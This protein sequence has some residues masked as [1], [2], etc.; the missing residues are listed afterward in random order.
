MPVL[1]IQTAAFVDQFFDKL[2]AHG[3]ALTDA[4]ALKA[5]VADL[6][7]AWLGGEEAIPADLGQKLATQIGVQTA[8]T[9]NDFDW[10]NTP[11]NGGPRN[12]GTIDFVLPDGTT[13]PL[14]GRAKLIESMAKGDPGGV[15]FTFST[16][17][18]DADPGPG[19][20]RFNSATLA[21]VTALYFDNTE[22]G[23]ATVTPWLDGF[24]AADGDVKGLLYFQEIETANVAVFKVTASVVDG[25][26]Y[27]KVPVTQAVGAT[28][29]A[30]DA[31]VAVTFT[32]TGPSDYETWKSQPGND[33]GTKADYLDWQ[34]DQVTANAAAVLQ[35]IADD[36]AQSKADAETARNMISGA[37]DASGTL[38]D[39]A[40]LVFVD[41]AQR[42]LGKVNY[43][44]SWDIAF[45][46]L[47]T[48]SGLAVYDY[49]TLDEDAAV[50]VV[51]AAGR[52]L[53]RSDSID[54]ALAEE[55]AAARGNRSALTDRMDV[56][57]TP[58][59]RSRRHVWGEW[60]LRETRARI[61]QIKA[62]V[63]GKQLIIAL[64][65]DSWTARSQ[66]YAAKLTDRLVALL[67]DAGGGWCGFGL[68]SGT[69]PNGNARS[70]LFTTVKTGSGWTTS[71]A[72]S[73]C[74]DI[75]HATSSTPGDQITVAG[76]ALPV[77]SAVRLFWVGTADGVI[78]YRW[79]GGSYTSLNV[80]GSGLQA[81]LL[82]GLP[83]SGSYS[84]DLEVVSGTC[85]LGG[86]DLQS[87]ATGVRVHK[88]GASGA[89]ASHWNAVNAAQWEAGFALLA[90]NAS[91]VLLGT[92]E[93][94]ANT[95]PTT[96][97][98]DI[99]TLADRL[100]AAVANIDLLLVAPCENPSA[101]VYPMVEY[102]DAMFGASVAKSA[103]FADLQHVFGNTI[104]EYEDGSV[105]SWLAADDIHPTD[106]GGG[107][108]ITEDIFRILVNA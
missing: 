12:D 72:T 74:P 102:A 26:G 98:T 11:A 42:I 79:N 34:I 99:Q 2:A 96:F 55:V 94:A 80:Q 45:A 16:T 67:G 60:F 10:Y 38:D 7:T 77:L 85:S 20:V 9:L 15:N 81:A 78:R 105:R 29:F 28:P 68:A 14:D 40:L 90:P 8:K 52:V 76:P 57:L 41:A 31:K 91:V 108:V 36:A 27:R 17:I 6:F 35:P 53:W 44:A 3:V 104:A 56:T 13:V 30:N 86:V 103:A 48:A 51:D 1:P 19:K 61:A 39:T 54:A 95:A 22:R 89:R 32:R 66:R 4:P 84:L 63:A 75:C 62:A 106:D 47:A 73:V 24:S 87:A 37:I 92:N 69:T 21:S 70:T 58:S 88:L 23:G 107:A 25:A 49:E 33:A 71:Y 59:G 82:S 93:K 100:R 50:V 101:G 43:D 5:D 46:A 83:G 97:G 18:T 64:V 65:G